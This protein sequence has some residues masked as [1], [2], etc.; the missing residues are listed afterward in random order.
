MKLL[1]KLRGLFMR[2]ENDI[3][4]RYTIGLHCIQA[5][6]PTGWPCLQTMYS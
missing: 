3:M 4:M 6:R 2:A 1:A 5:R